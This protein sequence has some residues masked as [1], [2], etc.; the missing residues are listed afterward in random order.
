[1]VDRRTRARRPCRAGPRTAAED[2]RLAAGVEAALDLYRCAAR[3]TSIRPRNACTRR[4][5]SPSTTTGRLS[6]SE[7]NLQNI[8]IR[9]EDGRKI[10]ARVHRAAR[11]QADLGR[12]FAD[13]VAAAGRCRR[14]PGACARHSGRRRH[15]RDDGLGNVRRAGEGHA[16]RNPPPRQGDQFRHHLRHF[17][18]RPRQPAQH[19]ARGGRRLY[20]EIFRALPRHPR[21]YGRD[22]RIL[23]RS[24]AM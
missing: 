13:R 8:P 17:G 16:G 9:T 4:M 7:P 23:P 1:M 14:H 22:A 24:M 5:H 15:S 3:L 6:S 2:S 18:V 11:P 19:R 21:L 10:R 12:L 20:Q